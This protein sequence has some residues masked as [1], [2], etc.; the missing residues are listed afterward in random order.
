MRDMN[1]GLVGD[2][3]REYLYV[4]SARHPYFM[5]KRII[6]NLFEI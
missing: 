4:M 6:T 2:L 3:S 1:N 5:H